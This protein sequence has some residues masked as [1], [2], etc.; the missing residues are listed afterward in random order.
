MSFLIFR[1][2]QLSRERFAIVSSC[3]SVFLSIF[4]DAKQIAGFCFL[5][6]VNLKLGVLVTYCGYLGLVVGFIL[7]GSAWGSC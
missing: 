7:E 3:S 1:K 5:F 4:R 2:L 6:H